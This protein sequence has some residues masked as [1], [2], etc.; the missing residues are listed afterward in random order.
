M[1]EEGGGNTGGVHT[2]GCDQLSRETEEDERKVT[3]VN[4]ARV[5]AN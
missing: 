1:G 4:R 2:C 5:L 3:V